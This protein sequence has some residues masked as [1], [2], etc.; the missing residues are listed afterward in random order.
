VRDDPFNEATHVIPIRNLISW[1]LPLR[2][3][4]LPKGNHHHAILRSVEILD[5]IIIFL[6]Q[7][8]N[9][10]VNFMRRF[11]RLETCTSAYLNRQLGPILDPV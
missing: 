9:G 11:E 2:K 3:L 10:G 1:S 5:D 4:Y 7:G 8:F 6:L